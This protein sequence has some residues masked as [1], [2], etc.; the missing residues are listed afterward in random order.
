MT[1]RYFWD[2]YESSIFSMKWSTL[3][4]VQDYWQNEADGDAH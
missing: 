4:E 1:Y 3:L 2:A